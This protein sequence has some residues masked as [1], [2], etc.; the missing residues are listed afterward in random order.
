MEIQKQNMLQGVE[1]DLVGDKGSS[2]SGKMG[3][4]LFSWPWQNLGSLKYLFFGPLLVDFMYSNVYKKRQSEYAWCMH[5]IILSSLRGLVHQ[6]WNTFD[7]MLFINRNRRLSQEG[8]DFHQIDKEWHWDNFIIL[9]AFVASMIF[10]WINPSMTNYPIWN[11]SGIISCILFHIGLSEPLYYCL[12]RL[13]HSSYFFQQYHWLH[14]SSKVNHPYTAGHATFLEHLLLC[15]IVGVPVI[16]TTLIGHGSMIMFYGYFLVF[17]FLRCMGHSNV[18]VVPCRIFDT[19]PILKYVIYTPT[20]HFIHH[21]DMKTNFCLFMPLFDVLGKTLN[22][23]SWDL[24]REMHSNEGKKAKAPEFVFLAHGVDIMSSMHVPF[25]FRSLSSLPFS[26]KLILFPMWPFAFLVVLV[27][28]AKSKPFLLTFC[29]LRGKLLQSWI[30]PRFGFMYFL[31]FAKDGINNQIEEAILMAD[32]IGVKVLSLAALNKNEALNGGGKLFVTKHPDLKVRVVHGNTLTAAVILNEISQ[33]VKEVFL[34]G[35]TSKLGRAIALYLARRQ[36]RVLMLTQ[37]TERFKSIQKEASPENQNLLVQV[38]KLQ[39]A[40]HCKTWIIGKW[41]TPREQRWAPAG[42]HFHQFVVPPVFEFRTD[43][44]YSKLAA[45]KLPDDVQG[46]GTCEYTM[47]R[48]V[49]HACHAGGLVHLLEGWTHHE[50]GSIDVDQIDL[51]WEAARRHG[52]KPV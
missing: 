13:L 47:E 51:V 31:P 52:F 1:K 36:V 12:H 7:N 48:G 41:T 9:Q 15:V 28:W 22:K 27:M 46:L 44:T 19:L 3:A 29:H 33:D 18:E 38:T 20:Y 40:K 17:D 39:A 49:V 37:S 32:R 11:I 14:H 50:V 8:I 6:L 42:T 35:A 25:V 4:P 2:S 34:T 43:C 21:K 16:A 24:H 5:V 10:L 26:T 23:I 45:M 30:V